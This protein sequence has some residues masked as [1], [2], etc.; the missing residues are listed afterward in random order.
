MAAEAGLQDFYAALHDAA[1]VGGES[2]L[3]QLCETLFPGEFSVAQGA[4]RPAVG[5]AASGQRGTSPSSGAPRDVNEVPAGGQAVPSSMPATRPPAGWVGGATNYRPAPSPQASPEAL[6]SDARAVS[7]RAGGATQA[8]APHPANTG[9]RGVRGPGWLSPPRLQTTASGGSAWAVSPVS[10]SGSW[11]SPRR[12]TPPPPPPGHGSSAATAAGAQAPAVPGHGR[13]YNTL[14]RQPATATATTVA[15]SGSVPSGSPA[16]SVGS[17]AT[18]GGAEGA[19]GHHRNLSVATVATAVRSFGSPHSNR[20]GL[21]SFLHRVRL[22][23]QRSS[24]DAPTAPHERHT[25]ASERRRSIVTEEQRL[26]AEG[27]EAAH[28]PFSLHFTKRDSSSPSLAASGGSG[29]EGSQALVD[30]SAQAEPPTPVGAGSLRAHNEGWGVS[31]GLRGSPTTPNAL[32]HSLQQRR[33]AQEAA[34]ARATAPSTT[35]SLSAVAASRGAAAAR[36]AAV[37]G[38]GGN[39]KKSQA[40]VEKRLQMRREQHQAFVRKRDGW[41]REDRKRH[42]EFSKKV[43]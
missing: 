22:R 16:G 5:G 3:A 19:P 39:Y 7:R 4:A 1:V 42:K 40:W 2:D 17:S 20:S 25:L 27:R 14:R 18:L 30:A 11:T 13:G 26:K 35:P 28:S 38:G 12:A 36:S 37:V 31:W 41:S 32:T 33:A 8:A 21:S 43:R 34:A 15:A 23:A 29:P 9:P 10:S 24:E 6:P